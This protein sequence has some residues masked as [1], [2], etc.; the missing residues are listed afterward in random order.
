M[1]LSFFPFVYLEMSLFSSIFCTIIAAFSL[2]GEYAVRSF[3]SNGVFHT[4]IEL[5]TYM[6]CDQGLDF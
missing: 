1:F 6:P 2:Y 3:L 5:D 4:Y